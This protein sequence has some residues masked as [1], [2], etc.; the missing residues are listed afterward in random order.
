MI[1]PISCASPPDARVIFT[2]DSEGQLHG[3]DLASHQPAPI[4]APPVQ[5]WRWDNHYEVNAADAP[6]MLDFPGRLRAAS[7]QIYDAQ[8][9]QFINTPNRRGDS[10]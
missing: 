6:A 4:D 5:L 2:E 8:H 9:G 10:E 7:P 1:S 3:E